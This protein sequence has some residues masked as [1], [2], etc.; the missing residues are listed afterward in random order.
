MYSQAGF[1]YHNG[2]QRLRRAV[3]SAIIKLL[4]ERSRRAW[5]YFLFVVSPAVTP[6]ITQRRKPRHQYPDYLLSL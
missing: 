6:F 1:G 5:N 3:S 4:L 2:R